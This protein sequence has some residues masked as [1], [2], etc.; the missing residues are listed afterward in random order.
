[1]MRRLFAVGI[2]TAVMLSSTVVLAQTPHGHV[3]IQPDEIKWVDGP[4]ALPKG[5]KVAVIEGNPQQ[6][7]PFTMRML[8]PAGTKAAPHWHP[9]LE[10][11]TVLAG[12]F[13]IGVG[14]KLDTAS[15]KSL[16]TGGFVVMPAKT[17]HFAWVDV[18]TVIQLHGI[19][20]WGITYVNPADDPAKK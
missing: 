5:V 7:G 3:M 19:G 17:P 2:A 4:P 15:G 8:L 13:N 12:T 10:H 20:P 14:E 11:V 1:M 16:P 6:E 18:E 9:G